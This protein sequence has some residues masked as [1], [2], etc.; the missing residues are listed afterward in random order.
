MLNLILWHLGRHSE[1]AV[2]NGREEWIVRVARE[3]EA[4]VKDGKGR[5]SRCMLVVEQLELLQ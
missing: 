2:N 4:A 3:G 1:R 5:Y